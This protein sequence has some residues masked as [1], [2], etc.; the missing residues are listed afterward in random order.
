ME[1]TSLLFPI[2]FLP[3]A[4]VLFYLVP[5][6]AKNAVLLV[7]SLVFAAWGRA[8]DLA[9]LLL[10]TVFTYF[11]GRAV[12]LDVRAGRKKLAVAVF[13]TGV[14][15]ILLLLGYFKY[16]NFFRSIFG[17]TEV[18]AALGVPV[19]L[20]FVSFSLLSFL[21]DC[22][23]GTA[24][25]DSF[26]GFTLYVFFFP[27][28]S[29]G[30]I[31][32]YP[33]FREQLDFR[34]CSR[35]K[36]E[37]GLFRFAVGLSK[38][39]LLASGLALLFDASQAGTP[40]VLLSWLGL[41]AYA[42]RLYFDFSGYTDMAL[43]LS[44]CF[45]FSLPENFQAPYLSQSVSEFWRRWHITLGAFF[46]DDV[47]IPLGGSRKGTSRT[48]LNLLVVWLLTGLWHGASF[49][50]ILWGLW[51]FLCI[52]LEKFV[53]RETLEKLPKFLRVGLTFL[54]VLFGWV[55]FSSADLGG[56]FRWIGRLVGV[57][58]A[59]GAPG[60]YHLR[61]FLPLLL[62]SAAVSLPVWTVP[63]EKLAV[64]FPRLW[65]YL[66]ALYAAALFLLSLSSM[67]SDTVTSFLY[68]AF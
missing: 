57:G 49:T 24:V 32:R 50:F 10:L 9:V 36:T 66:R 40:G 25:P 1:F 11:T 67:V 12:S 26:F 41:F 65:P 27:K 59:G 64:R 48:V 56:A 60:L 17:L 29:M 16:L 30:P 63:N 46:R 68:A 21:H 39:T 28:L 51:H 6:K 33:A 5:P 20:S 7:C 55:F 45:G 62:V 61:S 19:G 58:A 34:V 44:Q 53:L 38:K 23:R 52:F 47:Y 2:V 54:A 35:E 42:F 4:L 37:K 15:G 43:G 31:V 18:P 14:A 8:S 13:V 22:L 3:L